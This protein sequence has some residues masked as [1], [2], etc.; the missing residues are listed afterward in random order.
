[1]RAIALNPSTGAI[2][3][4]SGTERTI[5]PMDLPNDFDIQ[6]LYHKLFSLPSKLLNPIT[7]VSTGVYMF[8]KIPRRGLVQ[9][10][11]MVI[12]ENS[13]FFNI[14]M[15]LGYGDPGQQWSNSIVDGQLNFSDDIKNK[16]KQQFKAALDSLYRLY[17]HRL[18]Q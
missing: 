1:M 4:T 14:W 17:K 8:Q 18:P 12:A 13:P 3:T 15:I 9:T 2:Y 5:F 16:M 6:S 11:Y 7:Q 10:P